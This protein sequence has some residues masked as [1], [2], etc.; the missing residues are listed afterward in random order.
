VIL[1]KSTAVTRT[2]AVIVIILVVVAGFV[3]VLA[4][5]SF[6]RPQ[7]QIY[8]KIGASV[9]LTGYASATGKAALWAYNHA[10]GVINQEGGIDVTGMGR[11]NVSLITYDDQS[12][13]NNV[14]SDIDRLVTVDK[15]N[16]LFGPVYTPLVAVA[17]SEA[18]KL[19][20]LL[21]TGGSNV[22]PVE[23]MT[24]PNPY[25]YVFFEYDRLDQQATTLFEM[26]SS[27]PAD[28]RPKT[29]AIWAEDSAYG[30]AFAAMHE[31]LAPNYGFTVVLDEVYPPGA[32]DYTDLIVKTKAANPDV[33][34]GAPTVPDGI[35][36]MHEVEQLDFNPKLIY[37]LRAANSGTFANILGKDADYVIST[38]GWRPE[39]TYPGNRELV[40]NY[41]AAGGDIGTASD[42]GEYYS[43]ATTL[44]DA[45][46]IAS[47][48]D[49]ETIR[50][51][52]LTNTFS[53][54]EGPIVFN[55]RGVA[56]LTIAVWQY[57]QGQ[58]VTVYPAALATASL[59]Y[60][61]PPW[62]QR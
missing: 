17:A 40:A 60:P 35:T 18:E 38:Q 30:T 53:T 8:I 55:D 28:I 27:L 5:Q 56:T 9:P 14:I 1:G 3:G 33:V 52:L 34:I 61:A 26:L 13:P 48:L 37:L 19:H 12:D 11:L 21:L 36:I 42:L 25:H 57:Q 10:V 16:F 54:V 31:K 22:L 29:I 15:V 47:S 6:N 20:V 2:Q 24:S 49:T 51:V 43:L 45:I 62:S 58:Q 23:E 59:L 41:T 4:W 39:W 46:K 32:S 50:Q 44:F 7:P